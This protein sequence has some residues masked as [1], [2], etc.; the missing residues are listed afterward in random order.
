MPYVSA[1]YIHVLP[2]FTCRPQTT[3]DPLADCHDDYVVV[4]VPSSF[5]HAD[6]VNDGVEVMG[7]TF[8]AGGGGPV[9][10]WNSSE[11]RWLAQSWK[12]P[13]R[14]FLACSS[15]TAAGGAKGF[16]ICG[17]GE[18]DGTRVDIF[19]VAGARG[20]GHMIKLVESSDSLRG[21]APAKLIKGVKKASAAG[22]GEVLMIAGGYSDSSEVDVVSHTAKGG[23]S[24]KFNLFNA[25][26]NTW[27]SGEFLP[28][29]ASWLL[30]LLSFLVLWCMVLLLWLTLLWE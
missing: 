9:S 22:L 25:T 7:L 29:S 21:G 27:S 4:G 19:E 13:V 18:G 6:D 3:L 17:G 14:K 20:R 1:S 26:S 15:A 28:S 16:V 5:A 11:S 23:Y 24:S 30:L 12:I 8:F 10:V 2:P